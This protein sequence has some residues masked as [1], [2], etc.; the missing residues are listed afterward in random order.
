MIAEVSGP[1]GA[2]AI[3]RSAPVV[4]NEPGP[5]KVERRATSALRARKAR[6]SRA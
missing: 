5:M 6:T 1:S 4:K 2:L 3:G